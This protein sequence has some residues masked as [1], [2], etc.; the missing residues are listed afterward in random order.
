MLAAL[1][2]LFGDDPLLKEFL[3]DLKDGDGDRKMGDYIDQ[4]VEDNP[5]LLGMDRF[6]K[7]M[8]RGPLPDRILEVE[9]MIDEQRKSYDATKWN[10]D[11]QHY[12]ALDALLTAYIHTIRIYE[13]HCMY[14]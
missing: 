10:D 1:E 5:D 8:K 3:H 12:Y 7:L 4:F 11:E 13:N 9:D 2:N 6:S 14:K